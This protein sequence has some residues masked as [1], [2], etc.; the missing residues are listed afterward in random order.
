MLGEWQR[1]MGKSSVWHCKEDKGGLHGRHATAGAAHGAL[2]ERCGA[3]ETTVTWALGRASVMGRIFRWARLIGC[4][5]ALCSWASPDS[6][7]SNS[8]YFKCFK[9]KNTKHD[10]PFA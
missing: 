9:L 3:V 8:K 10:L 6:F 2:S 4:R 5:A 1:A 7:L